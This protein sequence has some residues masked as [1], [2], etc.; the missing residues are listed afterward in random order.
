MAP[1]ADA[2]LRAVRGLSRDQINLLGPNPLRGV[3]N[4]LLDPSVLKIEDE[5]TLVISATRVRTGEA[6]LF[7]DAKVTAEVL[8]A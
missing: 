5:P 7:R 6:R 3:L 1:I 8:L 4:G 2:L